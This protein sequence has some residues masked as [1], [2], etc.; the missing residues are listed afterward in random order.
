MKYL[1]QNI[2]ICISRNYYV[3]GNKAKLVRVLRGKA[4][5]YLSY[6]KIFRFQTIYLS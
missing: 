2:L 6:L 4:A 3:A 1:T 5:A